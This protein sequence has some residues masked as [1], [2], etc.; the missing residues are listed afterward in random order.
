[1]MTLA[2]VFYHIYVLGWNYRGGFLRVLDDVFKFFMEL[3][4]CM[5]LC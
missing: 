1:M 3:K 5:S 2:K 4:L